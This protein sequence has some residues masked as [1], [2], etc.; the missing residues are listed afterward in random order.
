[1][2]PQIVNLD[3]QGPSLWEFVFLLCVQEPG[4]GLRTEVVYVGWDGRVPDQL[5]LK[6]SAAA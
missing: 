5:G 4:P 6:L 3:F 2:G 1:M